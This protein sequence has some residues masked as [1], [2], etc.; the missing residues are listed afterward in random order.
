[1]IS[2]VDASIGTVV[3][4]LREYG[5]YNNTCV[6]ESTHTRSFTRARTAHTRPAYRQPPHNTHLTAKPRDTSIRSLT[7]TYHL[8]THSLTLTHSHTPLTH[9]H[10]HTHTSTHAHARAHTRNVVGLA[11]SSSSPPTTAAPTTTPTITHCAAPR[12][13]TSRSNSS[14]STTPSAW[15]TPSRT[16]ASTSG[17]RPSTCCRS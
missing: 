5:M 13:T 14:S 9:T 17:G 4:R 15:A 7:H 16:A 3:A 2:A 8:L 11:D 1:M 6:A 12:A 10:S